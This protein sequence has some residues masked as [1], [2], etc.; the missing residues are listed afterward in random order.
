MNKNIANSQ[1]QKN[2]T[3]DYQISETLDKLTLEQ[4]KKEVYQLVRRF[5]HH[6]KMSKNSFKLYLYDET[7]IEFQKFEPIDIDR[8]YDN[9][10]SYCKELPYIISHLRFETKF[11]YHETDQLI[12]NI[13]YEKTRILQQINPTS[14]V[15]YTFQ[16]N[17]FTAENILI[18]ALI[19][20]INSLAIKF[21]NHVN[22]NIQEFDKS[23]IEKLEQII[24][25]TNFLLKDKF[26]TQLKNYYYHNYNSIEPLF[27]KISYRIR[28]G[29][30][31]PQYYRIIQFIKIWK[32]Y[33]KILSE[34]D[35]SIEVQLPQFEQFSAD[36]I[37]EYWI[38]FKILTI[39]SP[40]EQHRKNHKRF[41][42]GKYIV[43]FQYQKNIGWYAEKEKVSKPIIRL[44]DMIVKK[45]RKIIAIIDAKNMR[46]D[47]KIDKDDENEAGDFSKFTPD[48]SIINQMIIY[49]DYGK[50]VDKSNLG[51]VLFADDRPTDQVI[52]KQKGS[53]AKILYFLNMHPNN[54]P[55]EKLKMIS[56][57]IF[58]QK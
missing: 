1:I 47:K 15:C 4:M 24:N 12:G 17:L 42:N 9:V 14:V 8:F 5:C 36:K 46:F 26:I 13:D 51:I 16:K 38:F 39:F 48:R 57:I 25:Y 34:S 29:K 33:N 43:E 45:D 3:P 52:V 32:E 28:I 55:E 37:F 7:P 6:E 49:L 27:E 50:D 40:I 31:H 21:M 20:G 41:S 2:Q 19:L 10:K 58:K 30:I 44:P 11:Q 56:E 35:S 54:M 53:N 23:H 22:Q 18:G